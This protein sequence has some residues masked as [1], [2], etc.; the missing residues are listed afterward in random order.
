MRRIAQRKHVAWVVAVSVVA[1][2]GAL[3]SIA[4]AGSASTSNVP[5]PADPVP[6]KMLG[7]EVPVPISP[8]LLDSTSGWVTSDGH[9]LTAVYAGAAGNNSN[10]GRLIVVRQDLDVGEQTVDSVD[11]G[12]TGATTISSAPLG[13]AVETSAQ[14]G[15][16]TF[17]TTEGSTGTLN[18]GDN[19]AVQLNAP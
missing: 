9:D 1:A 3:G 4:L 16:V 18:L 17:S 11:V 8:A 2:A 6:A 12:Q 14:S 19:D 7:S 15:L 10:V 13:P 5:P